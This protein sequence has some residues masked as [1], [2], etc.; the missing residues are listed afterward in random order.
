MPDNGK[1][2]TAP[3][4]G[5]NGGAGGPGFSGGA[6]GAGGAAS[7]LD[8]GFR[9]T[10][11]VIPGIGGGDAREPR[12]EAVE[13]IHDWQSNPQDFKAGA[14]LREHGDTLLSA[15]AKTSTCTVTWTGTPARDASELLTYAD[16]FDGEA[17]GHRAL[18]DH[19][20]ARRCTS[21]ANALRAAAA[22]TP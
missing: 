1:G 12:R 6:G 3:V 16:E 13:A 18:G 7:P 2:L 21:A 11:S 8:D 4:M 10:G 15:L 19:D 14:L 20:E 17:R 9:A 22:A 5:G